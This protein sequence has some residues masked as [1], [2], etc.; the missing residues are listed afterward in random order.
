M[1]ESSATA[2]K[3][4][5][6]TA[7][8]PD[9]NTSHNN[10][11]RKTM[12]DALA[13]KQQQPLTKE[14]E[15]PQKKF[16]RQRAHCNPLSHNDAFE[17]PIRPNLIDWTEEHYPHFANDSNDGSDNPTNQIAKCQPTVLDV[18]C[19]FGGLTMALGHLLPKDTFI[20]GMEIRAKV[21]EYVRLRI[22]AARSGTPDENHG[23]DEHV[24][25]SSVPCTHH[26]V[27]VLRTNSQKFL[28]NYFAKHSLEKL[29]FCFPDPHFKRKNHPRRIISDRLLAEYAYLL[30]PGTGKLYCITDVLELHQWHVAKCDAHPLLQRLS[31]DEEKDDPCI[32]AMQKETEEGQKV[33]RNKGSKYHAVY[34]RID[35]DVEERLL[36]Q[37]T[38][39]NFFGNSPVAST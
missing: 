23:Q 7:E 17:Y 27:S 28:P 15:R 21:A 1:E 5:P 30:Q 24:V 18:G 35:T 20:L 16:Y 32:E 38:A 39:D 37:V 6:S 31:P 4:A 9:S 12:E 3:A 2:A 36:H 8:K 26:N 22:V 25:T 13:A 14:G 34:R 10:K 11:K 19:G 33:A 29:F